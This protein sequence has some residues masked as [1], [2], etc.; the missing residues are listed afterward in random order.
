MIR[1]HP[2][3]NESVIGI[4]S[5]VSG[6]ELAAKIALRPSNVFKDVQTLWP[7]SRI[8]ATN[9]MIGRMSQPPMPDGPD[10][11]RPLPKSL[12]GHPSDQGRIRTAMRALRN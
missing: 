7:V 1:R 3:T 8:V 10:A 11:A 6:P 5:P 2:L 12:I 4:L 9:P